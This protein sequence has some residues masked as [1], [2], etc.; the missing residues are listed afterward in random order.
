MKRLLFLVSVL[1]IFIACS[2]NKYEFNPLSGIPADCDFN[3][4][5]YNADIK[6][7]VANN[8]A[9]NGCHGF[10]RPTG[11]DFNYT[12]YN[13]LKEAAG[14]IYNRINR[15]LNDP[16]HMPRGRELDSCDLYKLNVWIING[17]P[18]N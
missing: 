2:K 12:T 16:L 5:R 6:P 15:P 17:A 4:S 7:I 10:F 9:Y 18:N 3:Q 11:N 1:L 8:C 13:G 14:S